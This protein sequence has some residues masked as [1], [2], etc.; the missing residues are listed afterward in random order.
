MSYID[1]YL[2][3]KRGDNYTENIIYVLDYISCQA[4]FWILAGDS[5]EYVMLFCLPSSGFMLHAS[6]T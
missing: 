3:V 2:N 4:M 5:D 1:L 6:F